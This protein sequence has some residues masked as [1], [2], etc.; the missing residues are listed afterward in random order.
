MQLPL[1]ETPEA[2]DA[3]ARQIVR[4]ML[5]MLAP[6]T[7]PGARR[8][9]RLVEQLSFLQARDNFRAFSLLIEEG[10]DVPAA[11][12]ARALFEESIRWAWVDEEPEER[13]PAFLGEAARGHRLIAEAAAEQGIEAEVF[14]GSVVDDELLPRAEGAIRF[15]QPFE[16]LMDWMHN[17]GMYYLQYR[18]LSQYVHSS[19]LAAGSTAVENE[20][21][22]ENSRRL[23]LPARLTVI[24]N[25]AASMTLVFEETREGLSWPENLALNLLLFSAAARIAD[26]TYPFAPAAA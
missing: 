19:L 26:I 16:S 21:D 10:Q 20:G 17:R 24:R 14:F 13:T 4:D 5:D 8:Q 1:P 6:V 11:T 22:L 25:A 12:L 2:A 9:E 7:A 23:P 18:V 15:P 3:E